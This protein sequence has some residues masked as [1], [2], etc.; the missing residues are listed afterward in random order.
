MRRESRSAG[1]TL[2]EVAVATVIIGILLAVGFSNLRG[3]QENERATAAVRQLADLYRFAQLE[4]V[5]TGRVHLVF[6]NVNGTGDVLGNPLEDNN[7]DWVPALVLDDGTPGSAGQNCEIDAG[8]PTS[9][10]PRTDGLAWGVTNAGTNKAP[11]DATAIAV[12]SSSTFA[13]PAGAAATWVAFMPDGRPL[14]FDAACSMGQLGSGNGAAYVT[15]GERDYAV[16]LNP[17]GGVRVHVWDRQ[18]GAW[19]G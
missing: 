8:E 11:G 5:R 16:V 18:A 19:Q 12:S 9:V 3:W 15:N 13:T 17:L 10:L 2:L 4:A 7:G 1:M 14:G 6:L